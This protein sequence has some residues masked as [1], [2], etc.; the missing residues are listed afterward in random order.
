M[1]PKSRYDMASIVTVVVGTID[2]SSVVN[3]IDNLSTVRTRLKPNLALNQVWATPGPR[4]VPI[5]PAAYF[6]SGPG[7]YFVIK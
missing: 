1:P 7:S 2:Y 6:Q 4:D 5:R 3:I